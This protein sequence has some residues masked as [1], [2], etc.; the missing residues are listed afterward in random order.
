MFDI[1][2][3]D[4]VLLVSGRL[5]A[6]Q[7]ERAERMLEHVR[8]SAVADLEK[9]EYIS[10]AGISVLVRTQQR[11]M[12]SGHTLKLVNAQPRVRDVFHYASLEEI[13]GLE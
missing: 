13:F 7:A 9:L 5:D 3:K 1:Q 11:L 8:Q 4:G 2:M 10:S 6:S 12:A